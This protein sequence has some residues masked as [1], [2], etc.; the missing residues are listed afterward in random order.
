MAS[1]STDYAL[2]TSDEE[3]IRLGHQHEVWRDEAEAVADRAG[4]GAGQ[5]LVDL[6]CGPGFATFDLAG[7]VGPEGKV[8]GVDESEKFIDYLKQRLQSVGAR[9]VIPVV[10][11]AQSLQFE[12]GSIDGAFARWVLCFLEEPER[13][14]AEAARVLQPGGTLAVIDYF[15]YK[16]TKL[17]PDRESFRKLFAGF[18]DSVRNHGGSF[19]VGG[20]LPEMMH[21]CGL[22]VT[23]ISPIARVGRPGSP[24]WR[25]VGHFIDTYAPQLVAQGL[26]SASERDAFDK[27]WAELQSEPSAFF[28][29]PPMLGIVAVKR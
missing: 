7:R 17:F 11:D 18:Y 22:E 14:I 28:S 23:S 12:D 16:A 3:L 27:D 1:E 10:G 21:R 25:W 2:G 24:Y 5:T 8:Y 26:M 6:G 4:F 15:N 29:T 13:V 19:D 9:N 20:R